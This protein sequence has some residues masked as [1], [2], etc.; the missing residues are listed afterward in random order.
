MTATRRG[1][2]PQL[3]TLTIDIGGTGIKLLPVD[4]NGDKLAERNRELTP[5]PATPEAVLAV[6]KEMVSKQEP[7]DRVSVGFPGVVKHG[8]VKTAPNL[9]TKVWKDVD[10]KSAIAEFVDKPVRVLND[11]ELQGYG[12]IDGKWGRRVPVRT[13]RSA[14]TVA[15]PPN[16]FRCPNDLTGV[17]VP[18]PPNGGNG[19]HT[20]DGL[21]AC[22]I[23]RRPRTER[24]LVAV[25][26]KRPTSHEGLNR[27]HCPHLRPRSDCRGAHGSGK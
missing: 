17:T 24:D 20:V 15:S 25:G 21:A 19:P 9:G 5:K 16:I 4:D 27:L 26:R 12:V 8:V 22:L 18:P 13:S 1:P 6:I 23:Q 10:L 14:Q 7:F 11:A 3:R 2:S